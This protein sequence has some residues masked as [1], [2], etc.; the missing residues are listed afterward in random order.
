MK[1]KKYWIWIGM[2]AISGS[3]LWA[4]KPPEPT[5]E[6]ASYIISLEDKR[7][8]VGVQGMNVFVEQLNADAKEVGLREEQIQVDVELR[9]RLAGIM[10]LSEDEPIRTR[11]PIFY[12]RVFAVRQ[13]ARE[14]SNLPP[15]YGVYVDVD[16][17]E[18]ALLERDPNITIRGSTWNRNFIVVGGK[19]GI[20]SMV[21]GGIRDSVDVFIN[22]YLAANPK[23]LPK[24]QN[25]KKPKD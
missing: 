19:D 20:E 16:L 5:A 13:D 18:L 4:A 21:R 12:V 7:M 1:A 23:E 24:E 14:G 15:I 3:V 25:E 10:V 8:L 6:S 9:L 17:Y 22:D 11:S 2:L